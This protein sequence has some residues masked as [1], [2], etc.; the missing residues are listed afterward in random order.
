MKDVNQLDAKTKLTIALAAGAVIMFRPNI[1]RGEAAMA[2]LETAYQKL[3]ALIRARYR[4]VDENL[5]DIAPGS[6]ERQEALANQLVAAGATEDEVVVQQAQTLLDIIAE[7][8]PDAIWAAA[9][10]EPPAQLK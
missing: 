4:Q 1:F 9:P 5:L 8:D 3:K 7:K 2:E 10:A 6:A